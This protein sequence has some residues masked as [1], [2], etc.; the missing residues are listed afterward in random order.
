MAVMGGS[1]KRQL[2][3][4]LPIRHRQAPKTALA[5]APRYSRLLSV[6]AAVGESTL[7]A[8]VSRRSTAGQAATSRFPWTPSVCTCRCYTPARI[9]RPPAGL[10]APTLP[11]S[12][13]PRSSF[14]L[15][16]CLAIATHMMPMYPCRTIFETP[17]NQR[18]LYTIEI[19]ASSQE[20]S[21]SALRDART[22]HHQRRKQEEQIRCDNSVRITRGE[23]VG[24][25]CLLPSVSSPIGPS[26]PAA[27][28]ADRPIPHRPWE[29]TCRA[30]HVALASRS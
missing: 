24:S 14:F 29:P 6:V 26:S 17:R 20:M 22:K 7:T 19:G 21:A 2:A 1:G 5:A 16:A 25:V 15:P 12:V 18:P 13:S 11:L 10:P 8:R 27:S 3:D 23:C 28:S 4:G 9:Q 30:D